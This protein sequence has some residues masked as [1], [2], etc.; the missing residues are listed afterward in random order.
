VP[1]F[2]VALAIAVL[3]STGAAQAGYHSLYSFLGGT[4]GAHPSGGPIFGTH[5][6]LYG[7]TSDGGTAGDCT[8]HDV[9][10][11]IV[12]RLDRNGTETVLHTFTGENGDHPI[13][14]LVRD[15]HGNLFGVTTNDVCRGGSCG[16]VFKLEPD[17]SYTVLHAFI[18]GTHDC[19]L[20]SG[21]LIADAGGNLYGVAEIGMDS[22]GGGGAGCVYEITPGGTLTVLHAFDYPFDGGYPAGRLAIDSS[23]NLYGAATESFQHGNVFKLTPGGT[24]KVLHIFAQ[25]SDGDYPLGVAL[26]TDGALYGA[27]L[28]GGAHRLGTVFKI[29]P[30]GTES[31]LHSF[32]GGTADGQSPSGGVVLDGGGNLYG[33]TALGGDGCKGQGCGAAYRIAP[34]GT[35]TILHNFRKRSGMTPTGT[36]TLDAHGNLR[37][38]TVQGGASNLGT[39]FS[40]VP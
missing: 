20:P 8:G 9:H 18:G 4:D 17:G 10:C 32:A 21:G 15:A 5:G 28:H 37:G 31:L 29:T 11:G 6:T 35:E 23:G 33:V 30:D 2:I 24:F 14:E 16:T 38:A 26:G 3:A 13:G 7:V 12:Y 40:L 34:D 19:G 25:S 39:V 1:R 36:L 27:T 22:D